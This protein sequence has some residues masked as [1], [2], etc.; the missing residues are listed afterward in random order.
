MV[1]RNESISETSGQ[2]RE[3][4]NDAYG[5]EASHFRHGD[6][7]DVYQFPLY[8]AGPYRK[9]MYRGC[10]DMAYLVLFF[11]NKNGGEHS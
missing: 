4:Q 11:E 7:N 8:E 9:G 1:S 10:L 2:F 6:S 5:N 3:T